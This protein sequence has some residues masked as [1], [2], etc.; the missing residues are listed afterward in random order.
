[1]LNHGFLN[2]RA[3]PHVSV[4]QAGTA[5][6]VDRFG[7]PRAKCF[8]GNPLLGVSHIPELKPGQRTSYTGTRWPNFDP[9][10]IIVIKETTVKIDVFK[11]VDVVKK[12]VFAR[13][14]GTTGS[15]DKP[16]SLPGT[17]STTTTVPSTTTTPPVQVV[18]V[19]AD[20]VPFASSVT[21]GTNFTE[22]LAF[23]NNVS[24]SWFSA[25]AAEGENSTLMWTAQA[26]HRISTI[27]LVGNGANSNPS[28]RSG[29]GFSSA[30]IV[31]QALSGATAFS[32]DVSFGPSMDPN[33]TVNP[34]VVG[35]KVIIT[36]HHHQSPD[37]GGL[38]EVHVFG[39]RV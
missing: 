11:V 33:A 31:V 14:V 25:G 8:C 6:L 10:T 18:D 36:F 9:R 20:G 12:T 13:P 28:F 5:V 3:T 26:E 16:A 27:Q 37:C 1:V 23:D 7:V 29:F 2:G 19:S 38:S 35:V 32:Q 39:A 30:T 4:L 15:D 22:D 34:N 24:T 21:P 17:K